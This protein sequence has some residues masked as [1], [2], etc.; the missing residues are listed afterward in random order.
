[1][2]WVQKCFCRL[3][4][5]LTAEGVEL[6]LDSVAWC[7]WAICLCV[8]RV[9]KDFL[10]F[11][12]SQGFGYHGTRWDFFFLLEILMLKVNFYY[13]MFLFWRGDFV[14]NVTGSIKKLALLLTLKL[15]TLTAH[16]LPR[17]LLWACHSHPPPVNTQSLVAAAQPWNFHPRTEV[18]CSR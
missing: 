18:H 15:G 10:Y 9:L 12:A 3:T 14:I 2:K 7:V 8:A 4:W 16:T 13:I 17:C 5:H 11:C 6:H 1:M